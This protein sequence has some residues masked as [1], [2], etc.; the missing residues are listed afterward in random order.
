MGFHR[1]TVDYLKIPIYFLFINKSETKKPSLLSIYNNI[2]LVFFTLGPWNTRFKGMS[3][4]FSVCVKMK[5]DGAFI[6]SFN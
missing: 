2:K 4:N 3:S 1:D 5:C 6:Q